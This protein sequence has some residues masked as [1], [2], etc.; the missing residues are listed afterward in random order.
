MNKRV[1]VKQR[2]FKG[3]NAN[4]SLLGFGCMRLPTLYKDR[5]DI[6]EVLA[7]SMIDYAYE[8][9]VTYYDTAYPYHQGLS[10][11]FIGKALKKYPRNSFYLASKMPSWLIKSPE[12]AERIF[13]E[14]LKKCQ[15]EYFDYYLCHALGKEQFK[16]YLI[17]GVMEF[18]YKMKNEGKI[19]H[20][21]FS[22]HDTYDVLDEIIHTY[23]WDF[24]Q[25]QL[26]Y[27]DWS[28]QNAKKQ[29]EIVEQYG[30]PCIIMEPVRGGTLAVLCEESQQIFKAKEPQKSIAS[31]AIR[32]AASKSNAM[33]V[34][35]GMSN[36]EQTQDNVKTLTDFVPI[37]DDEQ[38]IIDH[39]LEVYLES[40]TIPC[41]SCGYCMPCPHGVDI[42]LNFSNFNEF[43]ISK[44]KWEF[45][46]KYEKEL[47]DSNANYCI[48]CG[49]CIEKCPQQIEIPDRMNEIKELLVQ[50]KK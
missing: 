28:F 14:Q 43:A 39:A 19:H 7:Q 1:T 34:L 25:L 36:L 22:F 46:H 31:W 3:I 26:N 13:N 10:E 11:I 15:V 37:T 21:G 29:Y 24:V 17:P 12:D 27:L 9:G 5:P 44:H 47:Q 33:T 4:P 18:L 2:A 40:Q 48:N 8:H 32:Y 30:V 38:K 49:E 41:T 6:D 20:L 35:S 42:P 50:L 45:I 23:K 16:P